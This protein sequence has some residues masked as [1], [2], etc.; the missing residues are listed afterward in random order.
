M[1]T[2]TNEP[3]ANKRMAMLKRHM[4]KMQSMKNK[5]MI[6]MNNSGSEEHSDHKH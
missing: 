5:G 4:A 1:M 2:I 3:D 6:M